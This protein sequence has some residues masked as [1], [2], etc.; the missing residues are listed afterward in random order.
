M[1]D[2]MNEELSF[3][4]DDE[5]DLSNEFSFEAKR[6]DAVEITDVDVDERENGTRLVVTFEGGELPYPVRES[7]WLSH[8]NE[9]AQRI[10]RAQLKGLFKAATGQPKAAPSALR[11]TQVSPYAKEGDDGR[12]RLSSFRAVKT[13][14][15]I[16][17]GSTDAVTL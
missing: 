6:I 2:V 8:T 15:G 10:G 4:A 11:G 12:I 16:G 14:A 13:T 7:F 3:T 9:D 5:I 1:A 17:A